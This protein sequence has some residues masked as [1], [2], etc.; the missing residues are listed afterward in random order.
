[1]LATAQGNTSRLKQFSKLVSP[2]ASAHV[3]VMPLLS[4]TA[5]ST[6]SP[7]WRYIQVQYCC[8]S[9][10][11]VKSFLQTKEKWIRVW[12]QASNIKNPRRHDV[13]I[14]PHTCQFLTNKELACSLQSPFIM[15]SAVNEVT[16]WKREFLPLHT[17]LTTFKKYNDTQVSH[18]E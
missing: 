10:P 13:S 17:V 5:R 4:L 14:S 11:F 3:L 12:L 1:M 18:A 8:C 6:A 2:F 16:T 9:S 15:Y 7:N